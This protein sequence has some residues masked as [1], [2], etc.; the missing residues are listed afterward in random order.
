MNRLLDRLRELADENNLHG[1]V[2]AED[3][4]IRLEHQ[5]C[6]DPRRLLRLSAAWDNLD[7]MKQM[8]K[9]IGDPE[10]YRAFETE[11]SGAVKRCRGLVARSFQDK[12]APHLERLGDAL[13]A[14]KPEEVK[15]VL[16]QRVANME[17]AKA[18]YMELQRKARKPDPA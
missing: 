18:L 12:F 15:L 7:K 4:V 10:E 5:Y 16:A 11:F 3:E 8:L 13:E 14:N 17:K 6:R 9:L 1:L 2:E